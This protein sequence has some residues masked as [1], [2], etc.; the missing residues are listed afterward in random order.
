ML[1]API[2]RPAGGLLHG[3]PILQYFK[4]GTPGKM[5]RYQEDDIYGRIRA[6]SGVAGWWYALA[7]SGSIGALTAEYG[8]YHTSSSSGISAKATC[9]EGHGYETIY[10]PTIPA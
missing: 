5:S 3:R 8:P 2:C 4:A 1:K 7:Q 6:E 9:S 10:R